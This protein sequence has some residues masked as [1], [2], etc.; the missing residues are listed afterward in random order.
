MRNTHEI[1]NY[2]HTNT[3]KTRLICNNCETNYPIETNLTNLKN[4]FAKYHKNEYQ[5]AMSKNEEHRKQIKEINQVQRKENSNNLI[6]QNNETSV[7]QVPK[8]VQVEDINEDD[9]TT[10]EE[11]EEVIETN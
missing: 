7:V 4:H 10:E 5:L 3:L 8:Y 1:H 2:F 6:I 11:I 9:Y